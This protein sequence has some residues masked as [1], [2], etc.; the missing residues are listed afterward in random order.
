MVCEATYYTAYKLACPEGGIDLG[1][2]YNYYRCCNISMWRFYVALMW[3][4]GIFCFLAILGAICKARKRRQM[5]M[6]AQHHHEQ[7]GHEPT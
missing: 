4:A 3:I 1:Y 7:Y 2:N 6:A 5:M